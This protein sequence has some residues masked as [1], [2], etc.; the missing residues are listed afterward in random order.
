MAYPYSVFLVNVG[1]AY[2]RYCMEYATPFTAE[3]LFQRA[4][5]V[6]GL[7]AVDLVAVPDFIK[8]PFHYRKCSEEHGL[9]VVSIALD[10]FTEGVWKQ[11]SFSSPDKAVRQKA[12]THAK[13]V[14][15]LLPEFGT[16]LLTIWPGQDGYD[17]LFQSDYLGDRKRFQDAV[18]ELSE[19]KPGIRICL[20]YKPKEPRTHSYISNAGTTLLMLEKMGKANVGLALDYGHALFAYENPAEVVA[21]CK[22]Y[23]DKLFHVH[24]NDNYRYWDDDM[25]TG[26]IRTLE[27][28]EFFYWLRE[29]GYEGHI[30]IDQFP[31]REDGLMACQES[32]NWMNAF[33]D[34]VARADKDEIHACFENKDGVRASKMMRKLLLG[35]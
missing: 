15:D 7:Y 30:T 33:Q 6:D 20:E 17:Y 34:I 14:I 9:K 31:Y 19:Y 22:M 29:T 12:M 25:I 8:D 3:E 5:A 18:L 13:E 10:I 1:T 4:A 26:S 16:D 32:V 27:Y 28:L 21:L 2:D 35:V 23:G 11:G 24:I